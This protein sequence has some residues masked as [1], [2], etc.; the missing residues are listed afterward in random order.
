MGTFDTIVIGSGFGGAVMACR[1]A[2]QGARVLVL[3][4]G[5]RWDPKEY[6]RKPGDAW[7]YDPDEPHHRNGWIDFRVFP[8]MMIA[9]GAAVGGGSLI[10]ADISVEAPPHVFNTGWPPEITYEGLKPHYDEVGRM[11]DVQVLPDTQLTERLKLM[12]EA[13]DKLGYGDR[14]RKVPIAVTFDPEWHYGLDDP[15]NEKHSKP[16]TNAHGKAQGT[17]IHLGNCDIGCDV[18]AKNTLELNYLARAEK[19]GAEIRPLHV[20]RSIAPEGTGYGVRFDR[21]E[22][23]Y[24]LPGNETADRVIVAA[25][26]LNSTELLLRCRDQYKTL[27]NLSPFLGRNWSSNGDFLTPAFYDD[28]KVS[29]TQ[30]PTITSVIDFL[31]GSQGGAEF[32]IQDGGFP[33]VLGNLLK[34]K[35]SRIKSKKYQPVLEGLQRIFRDR[36]PARDTMPWFAQGIDAANGRLHL[37]RTWYRPWRRALKLDWDIDKSEKV[38]DAIITMHKRLSEATG[39]KPWVPPTWTLLKNLVTPHP[40]GGCNMGITPANGVVDHRGA[41]FGYENLY[42]V[43]GA[44]IPEAIGRNPTRTIAALAERAA[45]LMVK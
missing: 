44:I 38:I 36:N 18:K 3:E 9:Q 33:D 21:I 42:V 17:C 24:L 34:A 22:N 32:W 30:G 35:S 8:D 23:R 39:G 6:P 19:H 37:G 4:R 7:F 41:V 10:Y 27:T 14:F 20:V 11:L 25:G 29:P 43:D 5:R 31:D 2:E 16:F 40:L 15:F 12:K 13:A 1:L 28:R 26:S 45:T